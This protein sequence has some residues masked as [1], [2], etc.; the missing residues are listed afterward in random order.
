M[1]SK[2]NKIESLKAKIQYLEKFKSDIEAQLI[3]LN[4]ELT[5]VT[6]ETD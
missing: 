4:Q 1:Q 6:N 2:E 3:L 5:K